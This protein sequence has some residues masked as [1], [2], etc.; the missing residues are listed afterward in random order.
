MFIVSLEP[1]GNGQVWDF[2]VPGYGNYELGGV[3]HHNSGKTMIA[4]AIVASVVRQKPIV[5]LDGEPLWFRKSKRP[6]LVWLIGESEKHIGSTWYRLL[7]TPGQIPLVKDKQGRIRAAKNWEEKALGDEQGLLCPPLIPEGEI[8]PDGWAWNKKAA[9]YFDVCKLLNGARI[10][11]YLSSGK[12]KMG[13]PVDLIAVDEDIDH[14]EYV[15]EWLARLPDRKG[16][17][18]WTAWP[19]SDNWALVRMSD[20]AKKQAIRDKPDVIEIK[21][22]FADN[23]FI[24]DEEKRKKYEA[25]GASG[26]AELRSRVDGEFQLGQRLMYPNFSLVTHGLPREGAMN[27]DPLAAV[28]ERNQW[29]PPRHWTR[30]LAFDPGHS[31]SALLFAAVPPPD[32]FGD[33]VVL[34]DELYLQCHDAEQVAE[35]LRPKLQGVVFEDFVIDWHYARQT[36]PALGKTNLEMYSNVWEQKGFKSV[37]SG[38]SFSFAADDVKAGVDAVRMWMTIRGDGSS[39]LRVIGHKTLNLLNELQLYQKHFVKDE[40]QDKPAGGQRDHL[41]DTLRYLAMHGCAYKLPPDARFFTPPDPVFLAFQSHQNQGKQP[42]NGSAVCG[43]GALRTA[44]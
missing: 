10:E 3:V 4:A 20:R 15:N 21:L 11:T 38:S 25:W 41:C 5:G 2:E 40:A 37:R 35:R 43:A 44:S 16:K 8:A 34:Y 19:W 12:V 7:F 13:D 22:S 30:Y 26:Q 18:L 42:T 17:Y 32:E 29:E 39:R 14:P 31:Y 24:D 9:D 6:Q 1:C 27:P 23:P 28:L 33:V 36:I